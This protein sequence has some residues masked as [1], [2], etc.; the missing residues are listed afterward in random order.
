M[1][2]GKELANHPDLLNV[3]RQNDR[4]RPGCI[5]TTAVGVIGGIAG[6]MG[7]ELAGIPFIYGAGAGSA[8]VSLHL[9]LNVQPEHFE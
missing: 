9:I 3:T 1:N 7:A 4:D 5:K 6:G 2:W 8:S